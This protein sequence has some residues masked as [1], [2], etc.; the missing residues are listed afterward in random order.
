MYS[1]LSNLLIHWCSWLLT[2]TIIECCS[3]TRNPMQVHQL[4]T[5]ERSKNILLVVLLFSVCV[6]GHYFW[7][8]GL[9]EAYNMKG[10][11][12]CQ[13]VTLST[14]YSES[15]RNFIWPTI[16]F[17]VALFIPGLIMFLCVIYI[18]RHKYRT[19]CCHSKTI[20]TPHG[21]Q[22]S[23]N[24]VHIKFYKR[25]RNNKLLL[26]AKLCEDF[27]FMCVVLCICSFIFTIP[28]TTF[29]YIFEFLIIEKLGYMP[30]DY[31]FESKRQLA[32]TVCT[33]FKDIFHA[34]KIIIYRV[35]WAS[36]RTTLREIVC[37][38]KRQTKKEYFE[39]VVVTDNSVLTEPAESVSENVTVL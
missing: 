18:L 33:T 11:W 37:C 23:N 22:N 28:Q 38:H 7:T 20:Q 29:N 13:F 34:L 17:L 39:E 15:F 3:F 8:F 26:D 9:Q 30:D 35:F 14:F 16:D 5:R 27:V 36:F 31:T 25:I 32:R 12:F 19:R 1:F 2:V 21:C 6:N 24:N 4:A 10:V